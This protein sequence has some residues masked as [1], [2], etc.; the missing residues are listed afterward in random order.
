MV[1]TDALA[2]ARRLLPTPALWSTTSCWSAGERV[3]D[4]DPSVGGTSIMVVGENI[5]GIQLIMSRA[6]FSGS[7]F[8]VAT[9]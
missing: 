5:Y 3:P 4:D 1:L 7:C 2:P 8:T 6:T 9:L